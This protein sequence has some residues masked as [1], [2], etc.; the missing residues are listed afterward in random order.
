MILAAFEKGNLKLNVYIIGVPNALKTCI[1]P[2]LEVFF[3]NRKY[4][5]HFASKTNTVG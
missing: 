5:P 2:A 3:L 1:K 4:I